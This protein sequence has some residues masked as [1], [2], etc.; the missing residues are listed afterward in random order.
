MRKHRSPDGAVGD[1]RGFRNSNDEEEKKM[2]G[3]AHEP[4]ARP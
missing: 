4:G 3:T 1:G 2:G